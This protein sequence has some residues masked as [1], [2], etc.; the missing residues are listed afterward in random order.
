MTNQIWYT[1]SEQIARELRP[2]YLGI[3]NNPKTGR[4][5]LSELQKVVQLELN[6]RKRAERAFREGRRLFKRPSFALPTI[7]L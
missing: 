4:V 6:V 1:D 2:Y 5:A 3:R 7:I